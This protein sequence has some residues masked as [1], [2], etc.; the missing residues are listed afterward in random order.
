MIVDELVKGALR[1]LGV[2]SSGNEIEASEAVDAMLALSGLYMEMVGRGTFGRQCD[3]AVPQAT[4]DFVARPGSRFLTEDLAT[5]GI[6]LPEFVQDRWWRW[7][8]GRYWTPPAVNTGPSYAG[9]SPPLDGSLVT[10]ADL[11]SAQTRTY[12]YDSAA[13]RWTDL[14]GLIM[15]DHAPLSTR[16]GNGLMCELAIRLTD[17]YGGDIRPATV[18]GAAQFWSA[19]ATR[20]DG[21]ERTVRGQFF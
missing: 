7:D 9:I 4:M 2:L 11:S 1:K 6:T 8:Y 10:L 15:A 12:V 19:I 3:I 18:Q 20:F 16:Y 14:Q 13:G 21:P 17:E 5:I